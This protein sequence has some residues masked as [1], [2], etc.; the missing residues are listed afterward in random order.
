[1]GFNLGFKGLKMY[2]SC[3]KCT[4]IDIMASLML[5]CSW[6]KFMYM[7]LFAVCVIT[8]IQSFIIEVFDPEE[9]SRCTVY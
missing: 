6:L 3:Y 1:M 7:A 2:D 9:S 8:C 5:T 4:N